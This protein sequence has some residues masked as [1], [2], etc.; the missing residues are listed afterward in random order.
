MFKNQSIYIGTS[1]KTFSTIRNKLDEYKIQ[2]R[3]KMKNHNESFL[4]FGRGTN[5][6]SGG[7]F[8]RINGITYEILVDKNDYSKAKNIV[9]GL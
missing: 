3:Y 4:S 5:R 1:L 2:Y 9:Q 8:G 6:S 7:N